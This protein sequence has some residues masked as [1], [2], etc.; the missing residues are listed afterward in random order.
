MVYPPV[1]VFAG[2]VH[3][4]DVYVGGFS[5]LKTFVTKNVG[6]GIP[7]LRIATANARRF[8]ESSEQRDALGSRDEFSDVV[9]TPDSTI[10][11]SVEPG[12]PVGKECKEM[13]DSS[14]DSNP[15]PEWA[16]FAAID[17]ADQKH[18]WRLAPVGS[19]QQEYG[20]LENTPEAVEVWAM[21]LQDRFGGRPIA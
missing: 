6:A 7:L 15:E 11:L 12:Q 10:S 9:W 1:V 14:K 16:A 13:V 2:I 18:F 21:Q 20:D 5:P 8:R 4:W 3:G 19:N 17:W